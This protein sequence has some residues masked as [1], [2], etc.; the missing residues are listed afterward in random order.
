M[1]GE[2]N[3]QQLLGTASP[4]LNEG[5]FVFCTVSPSAALPWESAV[6]IFHEKEG[7][8]MIISRELADKMNQPYE[9][10]FSWITLQVHSSLDAIGLTAAFSAALTTAGIPCNVVAAYHH[11]HIFVPKQD[12][13]KAMQ[14]LGR[15]GHE[16]EIGTA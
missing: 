14:V 7:V 2:T 4:H 15:L 13:P 12:A 5:G 8:T 16:T 6:G 3:L 9:T 1:P 10:V 11:D